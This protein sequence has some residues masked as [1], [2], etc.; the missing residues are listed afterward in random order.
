MTPNRWR[1]LAADENAKR[2]GDLAAFR[3]LG[4]S[5]RSLYLGLPITSDGDA[6]VKERFYAQALAAYTAGL[7][8][9]TANG[10]SG[11]EA[12]ALQAGLA[13]LYRSRV[14]T[15]GGAV[16]AEYTALMV[17]AATA[18]LAA[19]PQGDSR[20]RELVQWQ[21][22]GLRQLLAEAQRRRDWDLVGTLLD[23]MAALPEPPL[24]PDALAEARRVATVL[25]ALSLLESGQRE[26]A[27]ALAGPQVVD[28]QLQPEAD[29]QSL[30]SSWRITTT[31]APAGIELD[32]WVQSRA[33][34]ADAARSAFQQQIEAW[35][36]LPSRSQASM[37][38]GES[39]LP[40]GGVAFQ[41]GISLDGREAALTLAQGMAPGPDWVLLR[42][43]LEQVSPLVRTENRRLRRTISMEQT[44]DLRAAQAQWD[45]MADS[46]ADQALAI[47]AE[48]S[49]VN[50]ND[51]A[52]VEAALRAR[53]RA[54]NYRSASQAWRLLG[55]GSW[56]TTRLTVSDDGDGPAR[57]WLA[58]PSTPAET[59]LLQ[60]ETVRS[61][62]LLWALIATVVMLFALS[63]L[64][65]RL[66]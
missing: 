30:F 41:L 56:V 14:L 47:E 48:S 53:I 15:A 37:Q 22:D 66:L 10:A 38:I 3:R 17:Q 50:P 34:Q 63:A 23:Q 52:G 1:L 2:S 43:L 18:A 58:T 59:Y 36:A 60:A 44:L 12:G 61:T 13:S 51:A 8:R 35:R 57:A 21:A 4:D 28:A 6:A 27:M 42:A 20:R 26:A 16:D 40:D 46:L 31:M 5:Y 62:R 55:A 29:L 32:I 25:Q 45:A 19:M 33:E 54:A 11:A 64:L 39:I 65:W 9:A 24:A 49:G 7:E